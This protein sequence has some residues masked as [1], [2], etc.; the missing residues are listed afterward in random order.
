MYDPRVRVQLAASMCYI[1]TLLEITPVARNI[2]LG[3]LESEYR[4][5]IKTLPAIE[6]LAA[7]CE[8][9]D[10]KLRC[11]LLFKSIEKCERKTPLYLARRKGNGRYSVVH[12]S[13]TQSML[14]FCKNF[15]SW[16]LTNHTS[17]RMVISY[18]YPSTNRITI[19]HCPTNPMLVNVFVKWPSQCRH[20][21]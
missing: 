10:R 19:M 12:T 16:P 17:N 18:V 4:K 13:C 21:C 8:V 15:N 20:F 7:W 1:P 2:P 14:F 11:T 9:A 5:G 3:I 6:T